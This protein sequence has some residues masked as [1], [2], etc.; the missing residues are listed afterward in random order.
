MRRIGPPS[1]LGEPAPSWQVTTLLCA[2]LAALLLWTTSRTQ[3]RA[4]EATP[5]ADIGPRDATLPGAYR[6]DVLRVVDGDTV[7]VRVHVWLGQEVRTSV[8]LRGIDAPELH[9]RCPAEHKGAEAARRR[10]EDLV[11]QGAVTVSGPSP[12]KYFGRVLADLRTA[13]GRDVASI[14]LAERLARP[15]QGGTRQSWCDLP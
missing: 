9:A 6:A 15:Y 14:L 4:A 8:R 11:S 2:S 7:E 10:L 12:D 3:Q 1:P 5:L 13:D